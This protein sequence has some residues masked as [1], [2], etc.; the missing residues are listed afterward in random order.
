MQLMSKGLRNLYKVSNQTKC[1]VQTYAHHLSKFM[2]KIVHS[3]A[4][5]KSQGFMQLMSKGLCN[6]KISN[7]TKCQSMIWGPNLCT[8]ALPFRKAVENTANLCTSS[9]Q[10][11]A[12]DRPFSCTSKIPGF[13]ATYVQRF[14]QL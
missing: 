1:Q 4:Q 6:C 3:P 13:Y 8:S 7:Q 9:V 10:V 2:H 12:Q 14:A 11:Y 5:V